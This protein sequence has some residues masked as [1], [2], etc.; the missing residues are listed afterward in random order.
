MQLLWETLNYFHP[1]GAAANSNSSP[2]RRTGKYREL[3]G[4]IG[5]ENQSGNTSKLPTSAED[6]S[7][8]LRHAA[9][10]LRPD[11]GILYRNP[12][13]NIY[14]L[15]R[16]GVQFLERNRAFMR[17]NEQPTL[18][19]TQ[20][21]VKSILTSPEVRQDDLHVV[22]AVPKA[23]WDDLVIADSASGADSYRAAV[24]RVP[25]APSDA[26]KRLV[27]SKEQLATFIAEGS[28]EAS[29]YIQRG[30][31]VSWGHAWLELLPGLKLTIEADAGHPGAFRGVFT[32]DADCRAGAQ[33]IYDRLVDHETTLAS[34]WA[35]VPAFLKVGSP[36]LQ[37]FVKE[38]REAGG[39]VG[40]P[41]AAADVISVRRE[42][43]IVDQTDDVYHVQWTVEVLD[44]LY[45]QYV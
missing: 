12:R 2:E 7:F 20:P 25:K 5:Y 44:Q 10:V 38:L 31:Q 1:N 42:A 29:M 6:P 40:G 28:I 41:A 4:V 13:W 11:D 30:I 21:A 18:P 17:G 9:A 23:L 8:V 37:E 22:L 19:T 24:P 15:R 43:T 35:E 33:K 32:G 27:G 16:E 26:D 39:H 34:F 36:N 45:S 14:T 3:F